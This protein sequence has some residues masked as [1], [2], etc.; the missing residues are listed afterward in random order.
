M[1]G[2][3]GWL[4]GGGVATAPQD[5]HG[6]APR[7]GTAASAA[8]ARATGS[9]VPGDLPPCDGAAAGVEC[10][11]WGYAST[12]ATRLCSDSPSA[13]MRSTRACS[14]YTVARPSSATASR[15]VHSAANSRLNPA[16]VRQSRSTASRSSATSAVGYRAW[17]GLL[18]LLGSRAA[19]RTTSA[20]RSSASASL[21]CCYCAYSYCAKDCSCACYC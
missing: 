5:S 1:T 19:W 6:V 3:L 17:C 18:S 15:R 16:C 13:S 12:A 21:Y 7:P 20:P 9:T 2:G 14:C 11:V 8:A 10:G 4:A